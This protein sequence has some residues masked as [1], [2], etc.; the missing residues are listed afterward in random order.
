MNRVVNVGGCATFSGVIMINGSE[1]RVVRAVRD[2]GGC[3]RVRE[4][5]ALSR[6]MQIF[7]TRTEGLFKRIP[8]LRQLFK[9][10]FMLV[11]SGYSLIASSLSGFFDRGS[12]NWKKPLRLLLFLFTLITYLFFDTWLSLVSVAL[13]I[14]LSL[15]EIGRMLKYHG[16][17]HKTVNMF[18]TT[19]HM[20][21]A[22][23]EFTRQ[24]SRIH[25]RCG[26]NILV[27][28]LPLVL[29]YS[30]LLWFLPASLAESTVLDFIASILLMAAGME[31][32]KLMQKPGMRK[33]LKPGMGLQRILTTR[34]PEDEQ[35]EVALYAL[36]AAL[37]GK[38]DT[39][40]TS[41]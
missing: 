13:L 9:V 36:R 26:T 31:L 17:E 7:V 14:L 35:I 4:L 27:I 20:E 33:F 40:T 37:E 19:G 10:L 2:S 16:A 23:V 22:S 38:T 15:K 6:T 3:I 32:F 24:F 21:N 34:E 11:I 1:G 25:P 8:I 29:L 39:P 30:V 5:T 41:S 18:D 28:L 12:W